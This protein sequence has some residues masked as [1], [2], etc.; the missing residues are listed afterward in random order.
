MTDAPAKTTGASPPEQVP[1]SWWVSAVGLLVSGG[2]FVLVALIAPDAGITTTSLG[3][4]IALAAVF[5]AAPIAGLSRRT[6]DGRIVSLGGGMSVAG[7]ATTPGGNLLGPV[8]AA[9]GLFLLLAGA[10]RRPLFTVSLITKLLAYGIALGA[11]MWLAIG[12]NILTG[13]VAILSALIVST[14]PN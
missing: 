13:L 11:A 10:S 7:V 14:S 6:D 4:G 12:T 1:W 8:M 9:T 5:A 3:Q 2:V